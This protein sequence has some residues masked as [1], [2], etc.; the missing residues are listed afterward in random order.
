[1]T[2]SSSSL[3]VVPFTLQPAAART[4][5]ETL[6]FLQM[7]VSAKVGVMKPNPLMA[8][9]TMIAMVLVIFIRAPLCIFD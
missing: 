8:V 4:S 1:M 3:T 6:L 5:G 7:S 2:D 9:V